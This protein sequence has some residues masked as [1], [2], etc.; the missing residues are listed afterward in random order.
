[1]TADEQSTMCSFLGKRSDDPENIDCIPT[2]FNHEQERT[3]SE[4][5]KV[6]QRR[7]RHKS[8]CEKRVIITDTSSNSNKNE[9]CRGEKEVNFIVQKVIV[10]IRT[11]SVIYTKMK[12]RN[13]R[14]S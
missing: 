1:M 6:D 3:K 10:H 5:I 7:K 13:S 12:L 11:C 14:R 9:E 2:I 4:I 8:I